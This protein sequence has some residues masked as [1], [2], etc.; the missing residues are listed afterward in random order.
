MA[1]GYL[2]D[3][4]LT[5][6]WLIST[7]NCSNKCPPE[8]YFRHLESRRYLLETPLLAENIPPLIC[9]SYSNLNVICKISEPVFISCS[10]WQFHPYINYWWILY[11]VLSFRFL[12]WLWFSFGLLMNFLLFFSKKYFLPTSFN[13]FV[14]FLPHVN[15]V[16]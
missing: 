16:S 9:D 8:A 7:W 12:M 13:H 3:E 4:P 1:Q 14:C 11:T 15:L 10:G 2:H 6:Y 5:N